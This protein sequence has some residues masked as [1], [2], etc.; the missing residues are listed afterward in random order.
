[1]AAQKKSIGITDH[2]SRQCAAL[3]VLHGR[4]IR[5]TWDANIMVPLFVLACTWTA[6]DCLC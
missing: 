5:N 2:M 3:Y 4:D 1:M 6:L